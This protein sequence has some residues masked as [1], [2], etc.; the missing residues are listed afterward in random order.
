MPIID[1]YFNAINP[2]T[3]LFSYPSFMKIITGWFHSPA[4]H[5]TLSWAAILMVMSLGLQSLP[6]GHPLPLEYSKRKHWISYSLRNAQSLIPEL[7]AREK[8]LLGPQVLVALA[9]SFRQSHGLGPASVMIGMA[10]RSAHRMQLH[11]TQST[12]FFTIEDV[13]QRSNVFWVLY[14]LDK[15]RYAS[16]NLDDLL[17]LS[18]MSVCGLKCRH[19]CQTPISTSRSHRNQRTRAESFH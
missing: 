14:M 6:C 17:I 1:H 19:C 3:P 15:V 4:T 18:R 16:V 13:R 9:L 5:D 8:D 2:S 12:N 10:V 11:S 7:M